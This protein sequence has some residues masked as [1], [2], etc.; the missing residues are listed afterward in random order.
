[1]KN[2]KKVIA[3]VLLSS[4]L[5]TTSSALANSTNTTTENDNSVIES[6]QV[7]VWAG[8][9]RETLEKVNLWIENNERKYNLDYSDV[10][11]SLRDVSSRTHNVQ[12]EADLKDLYGEANRLFVPIYKKVRSLGWY[13]YYQTKKPKVNTFKQEKTKFINK[14]KSAINW[15]REEGEKE[16][17]NF[18]SEISKLERTLKKAENS[19]KVDDLKSLQQDLDNVY[20]A[21]T[22]REVKRNQVKTQTSKNNTKKENKQSYLSKRISNLKT[23][24]KSTIE[25]FEWLDRDLSNEIAKLNDL[26]NKADK[27]N[28]DNDVK[29]IYQEL[30][31]IQDSIK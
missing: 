12:T 26:Y 6:V 28:N 25:Y 19:K 8:Q 7:Q 10:K 11:D 16:N 5:L 27:T 22:G 2:T 24:I 17:K 18:S 14:I 23:N 30:A 31:T 3:S 1:M 29:S 13:N 4:M 9:F 21:I 15:G 20:K